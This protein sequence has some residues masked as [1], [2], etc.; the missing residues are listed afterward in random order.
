[1]IRNRYVLNGYC[2]S[3][4]SE[5]LTILILH[6]IEFVSSACV[7]E[8]IISTQFMRHFR[9]LKFIGLINS[10]LYNFCR[11]MLCKRGLR[12]IL[13]PFVSARCIK[14]TRLA[15]F[16]GVP[17]FSGP[18]TFVPAFSG[19]AFSDLPFSASP[20]KM[21]WVWPIEKHPTVSGTNP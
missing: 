15:A 8:N 3:R 16:L 4:L 2:V 18:A 20:K 13:L 1:V 11:A 10:I 17:A 14:L 7:V 9:T 5:R 21:D 6:W 19:P 12:A